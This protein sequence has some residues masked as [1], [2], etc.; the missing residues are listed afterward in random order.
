[1][2]KMSETAQRKT[3][4][5]GLLKSLYEWFVNRNKKGIKQIVNNMNKR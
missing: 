3:N 5:G 4:G 2:K 1:M